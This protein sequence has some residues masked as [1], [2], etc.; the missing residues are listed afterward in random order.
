MSYKQ[1]TTLDFPG[2]DLP[3]MDTVRGGGAPAPSD[4]NPGLLHP[5]PGLEWGAPSAYRGRGEQEE[6]GT[7][8]RNEVPHSQTGPG[9]VDTSSPARV[10][11]LDR[12][13][14]NCVDDRISAHK[15]ILN[16]SGSYFP[17][18]ST[19]SSFSASSSNSSSFSSTSTSNSS[20]EGP[21][22]YQDDTDLNVEL[23]SNPRDF[24]DKTHQMPCLPSRGF[25]EGEE[26][27]RSHPS[28]RDKRHKAGPSHRTHMQQF[29]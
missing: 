2:S 25:G 19:L 10:R 20:S 1:A 21:E 18:S 22:S 28:L 12:P 27:K 6:P 3:T 14:L 4:G 23:E 9:T 29:Q 13:T 24:K 15:V 16:P 8:G 5:T 7:P 11:S 17:P 26:G